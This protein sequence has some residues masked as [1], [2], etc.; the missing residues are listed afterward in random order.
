[1][2]VSTPIYLSMASRHSC[3]LCFGRVRSPLLCSKQYSKTRQHF[4]PPRSLRER[5]G[6]T[7]KSGALPKRGGNFS[8][9]HIFVQNN[10][11]QQYYV[12]QQNV[13]KIWEKRQSAAGGDGKVSQLCLELIVAWSSFSF[14]LLSDPIYYQQKNKAHSVSHPKKASY[15]KS[16][17]IIVPYLVY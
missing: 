2:G 14:A 12:V 7:N 4:L 3:S 8:G 13:P 9:A 6:G 10:I 15:H 1:M 11:L 5:F 17:F 16:S